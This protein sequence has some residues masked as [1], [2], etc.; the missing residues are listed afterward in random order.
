MSRPL[1]AVAI[2]FW[3]L[4]VS[5]ALVAAVSVSRAD[6]SVHDTSMNY[7]ALPAGRGRDLMNRYC[8]TCH[9]SGIVTSNR[10]S[11]KAWDGEV[12]KM[13]KAF[14]AQIPDADQATIAQ[15]LATA[16]PPDKPLDL[17]PEVPAPR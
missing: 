11:A 8:L 7:D 12:K 1:V 16:L 3:A 17:P 14:G 4:A 2:A 5:A 13:V 10:L 6:S 15:Y 9:S